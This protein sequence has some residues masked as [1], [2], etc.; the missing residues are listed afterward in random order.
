MNLYCITFDI[1]SDDDLYLFNL[2]RDEQ[3]DYMYFSSILHRKLNEIKD[4]INIM[5]GGKYVYCYSDNVYYYAVDLKYIDIMNVEFLHKGYVCKVI[6]DNDMQWIINTIDIVEESQIIEEDVRIID[7][8][9][10]DFKKYLQGSQ[11]CYN[12]DNLYN[13][14]VFIFP[15]IILHKINLELIKV[16]NFGGT[17]LGFYQK[18][19]P[20]KVSWF[21]D[22]NKN[23]FEITDV[24]IDET[25]YSFKGES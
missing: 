17:V 8:I 6:S 16:M 18:P 2:T 24:E 7:N 4:K 19:D 22:N 25:D 13:N 9:P 11:S 14:K 12:C 10:E 15:N 20:T 1:T 21:I 3:L 5:T 23:L